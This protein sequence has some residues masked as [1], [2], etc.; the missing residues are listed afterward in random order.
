MSAL[1]AYVVPRDGRPLGPALEQ[2]LGQPSA[3]GVA[4][5]V[6]GRA[7]GSLLEALR[8]GG[9]YVIA[10]AIAGALV[11][12]D[13]R[14][15]YLKDLE[16]IGAT[17]P[18]PDVFPA[19]VG[20]LEREELRPLL[21]RTYPLAEIRRA[22]ADFLEKRHVGKLVLVPPYANAPASRRRRRAGHRRSFMTRTERY[23]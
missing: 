7:F 8:A 6:G 16:A 15:L 17:V 3:D 9:R 12:F 5:V 13:L 21:A 19:L 1:G 14:T 20:H 10:G 22:Q 18:D 23:R 11:D 2:A 4:D